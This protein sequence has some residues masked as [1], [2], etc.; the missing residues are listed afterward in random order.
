MARGARL[1]WSQQGATALR[2]SAVNAAPYTVLRKFGN[3][4]EVRRYAKQT[5]VVTPF[6]EVY[7]KESYDY[8]ASLL[9]SVLPLAAAVC[10]IYPKPCPDSCSTLAWMLISVHL[11]IGAVG[12]CAW[13]GRGRPGGLAQ[14]ARRPA[15]CDP[16]FS[17]SLLTLAHHECSTVVTP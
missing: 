2:G 10:H 9:L 12:M 6:G 16:P 7:N 1:H 14:G 13:Q 5:R 3:G 15:P 4:I 17:P 8:A 11:G